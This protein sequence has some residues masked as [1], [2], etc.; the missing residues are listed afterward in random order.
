MLKIIHY[1]N[2]CIGC[3]VC[4]EHTPDCWFIDLDGKARLK[5]TMKKKDFYVRDVTQVEVAENEQA[6]KDCP[7]KIIKVLK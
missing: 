6:A 7:V 5:G 4:I 1:R 3:G 2:K